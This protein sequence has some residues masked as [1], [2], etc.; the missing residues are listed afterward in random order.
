MEVCLLQANE[1]NKLLELRSNAGTHDIKL[2]HDT[3][4]QLKSAN[5]D[6]SEVSLVRYDKSA[7]SG[8]GD[9]APKSAWQTVKGKVDVVLFEGWMLGFRPLLDQAAQKVPC[10][11]AL[12]SMT[13][14]HKQACTC[15]SA[16][17]LNMQFS[18]L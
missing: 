11:N 12:V 2:A 7:H 6:S 9:R 13:C 18:R 10:L 14:L 8:R 5:S 1:G 17:K 4:Q 16:N 15:Q 3:L